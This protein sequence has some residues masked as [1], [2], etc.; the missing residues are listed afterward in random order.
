MFAPHEQIIRDVFT[1]V[2]T[3][4]AGH[5]QRVAQLEQRHLAVAQVA[6][7]VAAGLGECVNVDVTLRRL[8]KDEAPSHQAVQIEN[9]QCVVNAQSNYRAKYVVLNLQNWSPIRLAYDS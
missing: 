1:R 3:D 9:E 7:S 8:H 4:A 6:S 5:S 2:A